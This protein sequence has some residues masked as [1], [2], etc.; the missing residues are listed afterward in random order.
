MIKE[1]KQ[2]IKVQF[3]K[4]DWEG[5]GDG[6]GCTD[7]VVY[8]QI[9]LTCET[10]WLWADEMKARSEALFKMHWDNRKAVVEE[11]K[12]RKERLKELGLK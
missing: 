8:N 3:C 2:W 7:G 10:K 9:C 6:F 4:H 5:F 1:I 12:R 11:A